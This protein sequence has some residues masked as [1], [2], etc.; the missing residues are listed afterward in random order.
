MTELEASANAVG[1]M[2]AGLF[3][4]VLLIGWALSGIAQEIDRR[5]D[6][7]VTAILGPGWRQ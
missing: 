1:P 4:V 7:E 3:A 5:V 2:V 6:K